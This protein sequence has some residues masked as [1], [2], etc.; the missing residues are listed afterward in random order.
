MPEAEY[1]DDPTILDAHVLWR[2]VRP[3]WWHYDE[4]LGRYRPNSD[5]FQDSNDGTPMS[6]FLAE[7]SLML[8]KGP[9][10]CLLSHAGYGLVS[11]T[12][13]DARD[14]GLGISRAPRPGEEAHAYVFG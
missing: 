1:A 10:S 12:A 2:R 4:Q 8:G 7:V 3:G 9:E 13:Q 6:V 5:S 14:A 11:I